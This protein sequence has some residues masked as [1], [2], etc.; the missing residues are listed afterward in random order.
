M[1]LRYAHLAP[2][3]R[4]EA[5]E[6]LDKLGLT[7]RLWRRTDIRFLLTAMSTLKLPSQEHSVF[8]LKALVSTLNLEYWPVQP[9]TAGSEQ[10]KEKTMRAAIASN[11][12]QILFPCVQEQI[13]WAILSQATR[14]A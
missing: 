2:E 7:S 13:A 8:R 10:G 14:L 1:T 12:R 11:H 9:K 6:V 4:R 3:H 5:V